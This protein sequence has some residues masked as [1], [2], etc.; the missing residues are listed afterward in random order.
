MLMSRFNPQAKI[1]RKPKIF[2]EIGFL[3]F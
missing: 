1:F 2:D 3:G